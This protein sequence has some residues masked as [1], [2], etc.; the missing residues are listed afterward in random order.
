[1]SKRESLSQM[2]GRV[3]ETFG[4]SSLWLKRSRGSLEIELIAVSP[5]ARGKG[6]GTKAMRAIVA[7]A[8]A[9][10]LAL[11]LTPSDQYGSDANLLTAWYCSFGFGL[12]ADGS[13]IRKAA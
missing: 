6:A 8:D 9:N 5:E 1:M 3:S 2:R 7:Y 10:G 4:L 13:M 12:L 11:T